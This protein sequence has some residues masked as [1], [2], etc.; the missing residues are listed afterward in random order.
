[1]LGFLGCGTL[2]RGIQV[3]HFG[4]V[5]ILVAPQQVGDKMP[6][7]DGQGEGRDDQ[8]DPTDHAVAQWWPW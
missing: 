3:L 7:G 1:M 8:G 5:L 6:E 2:E 4:A